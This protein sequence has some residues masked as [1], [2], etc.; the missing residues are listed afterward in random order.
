MYWV[1]PE[2]DELETLEAFETSASFAGELAV[3]FRLG[4]PS[5]AESCA[6]AILA[7]SNSSP[8]PNPMGSNSKETFA[9]PL[10]R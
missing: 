3:W 10:T 6:V 4:L 1:I 9:I 8:F 5:A 2:S 7:S